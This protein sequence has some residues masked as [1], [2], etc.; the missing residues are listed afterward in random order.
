MGTNKPEK[1]TPGGGDTPALTPA[2][3]VFDLAIP[4]RCKAELAYLT[5]YISEMLNQ[6]KDGQKK[7]SPIPVLIGPDVW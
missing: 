7:A 5:G 3:T 4:E 6:P 1:I 2:T